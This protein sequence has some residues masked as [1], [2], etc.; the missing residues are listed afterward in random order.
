MPRRQIAQEV[1]HNT[2]PADDAGDDRIVDTTVIPAPT[3]KP[4]V[5]VAMADIGL[6]EIPGPQHNARVVEMFRKAGHAWVDDDETAWCAAA[7]SAW[8]EESG[9]PSPKTL[10]ARQ[11]L[12]WG[13]AIDE[14]VPGCIVVMW[15]G[16]PNGWQGHVGIY[17]GE[18][19]GGRAIRVLGGNQ[20][21]GVNVAE[22]SKRR[23]YRG[24]Y[25]D[26]VLGY[27]M[28]RKRL[29]TQIA[30]AGSAAASAAGAATGGV[31][32]ATTT[33]TDAAKPA[34]DALVA[35]GNP[36]AMSIGLWAVAALAL[37]GAGLAIY[38]AWQR[39]QDFKSRGV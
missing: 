33:V 28:P 11:F 21:N 9:T 32:A 38:T 19:Q 8:L 4:W 39:G 1:A 23:K 10:G 34:A 6:Q 13:R 37:V 30:S 31:I 14:P 17:M 35:T 7:M 25:Y 26:A 36:A 2:Q 15:R 18:A 27:R 29:K 12:K 3:G 20:K 16:S 5:D 22:F 24:K